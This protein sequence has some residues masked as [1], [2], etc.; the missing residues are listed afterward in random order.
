M[1]IRDRI[2]ELKRVKASELVDHAQNWRLHPESQKKALQG[3]LNDI[4]FADAVL[5]RELG[6]GRYGIIDGHCRKELSGDSDIPVLVLDVDE[7]EAKK[8]LATLDPLSS[9]AEMDSVAL[10]SLLAE[11][12]TSNAD[13]QS[14]LDNLNAEAIEAAVMAKPAT[15]NSGSVDYYAGKNA[16]ISYVLIFDNPDQQA[17]WFKFLKHLKTKNPESPTIA[18]SLTDFIQEHF[19]EG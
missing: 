8:I 14:L 10:S 3:V 17:T 4:G 5:V 18:Q 1:Q 13:V 19:N 16:V 2:K 9:M 7:K 12:E 6:D 15:E 11:I